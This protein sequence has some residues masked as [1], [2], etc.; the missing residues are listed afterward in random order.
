MTILFNARDTRKHLKHYS[1]G[2]MV[3][4]LTPSICFIRGHICK[5]IK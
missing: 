4:R 3:F 5:A 2:G 1:F